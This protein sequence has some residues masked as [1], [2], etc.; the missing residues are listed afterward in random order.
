MH[1]IKRHILHSAPA[2]S[3][4]P[5]QKQIQRETRTLIQCYQNSSVALLLSPE[6][7]I[8][9]KSNAWEIRNYKRSTSPGAETRQQVSPL[10]TL[11]ALPW[12]GIAAL[13][14]KSEQLGRDLGHGVSGK[15][16]TPLGTWKDGPLSQAPVPAPW[17][18]CTRIGEIRSAIRH[19]C[20][21]N[22]ALGS[23]RLK[24]H[25]Q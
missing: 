1:A 6:D 16:S 13:G 25:R 14:N 2:V 3:M 18:A 17:E 20:A 10:S 19:G 15:P 11:T 7:G 21:T 23:S 24:N 22:R 4:F 12:R 8:Q 5:L 9:Q